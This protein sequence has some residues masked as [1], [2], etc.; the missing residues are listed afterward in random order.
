MVIPGTIKV[1]YQKRT[2]TYTGQLAYVIYTDH[3]GKLRKESS[4][5][6]WRDKK[7]DPQ[8][9]ENKPTS[10]FVLNKKVGGTRYDWNPRQTY[11]RVWDPRNF[12]FEITVPNLLFIL[13]ETNSIKGKGLEGEFVYAWDGTQLVLL[14]ACSKE[15]KDCTDFTT[16]QASKVTKKDMVEGCSYLMRDMTPVMYLG[17]HG[18]CVKHGYR[19]EDINYKPIGNHHVFLNL[20]PK[21]KEDGWDYKYRKYIHQTGFTKIAVKT[22]EEPLSSYADE[23]ESFRESKYCQKTLDLKLVKAIP[24]LREDDRISGWASQVLLMKEGE[25]YF[26]TRVGWNLQYVLGSS[27]RGRYYFVEKGPEFEPVIKDGTCVLPKPPQHN[28]GY[29][30]SGLKK[31][32]LLKYDFYSAIL[33]TGNGNGYDLTKAC[34]YY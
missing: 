34:Y 30:G 6:S 17:K 7:I 2:D 33:E 10:G 15:Y 25:K 1:G 20:K 22:S 3:K 9:F 13:Q 23:Y 21:E 32:D 19:V 14:P 5:E 24:D 16:A 12:E 26:A 28:R 11:A 27:P 8:E 18:F 4:W 29:G 31:E